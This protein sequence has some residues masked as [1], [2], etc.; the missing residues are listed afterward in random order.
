MYALQAT[1]VRGL[2][3][4]AP[5]DAPLVPVRW[6]RDSGRHGGGERFVT[7]GQSAVFDRASVNASQVHYDDLPNRR[8]GSATALSTI[9]HP[10]NPWAA[11]VHAHISYTELR[12]GMG[13]WRL[14]ADL[15]PAIALPEQTHAFRSCLEDVAPEHFLAAS[16]QGDRYFTIPALGR[17]R[18]VVHFYLEG[19]RTG[20][21]DADAH[22]ARIFGEAV[23]AL[24]PRLVQDAIA[25]HPSPGEGDRRA[26]L[27][28]HTLYL[29]QVLTLDRGTTS[30]L[31]VHDQNDLGI[32]GSLPSRVDPELFAR[33]A[34]RAPL[35]RMSWRVALWLNWVTKAGWTTRS[36]S[37]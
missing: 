5:T 31:L 24:Y 10:R 14:M 2:E 19:Y 33:W 35:P 22:L 15:N 29:F 27:H 28:Y 17:R 1:L 23:I 9:V 7:D 12:S 11:S 21:F 25:A 6:L 36:S 26:Q 34:E 32:L 4:L 30:G 16:I 8:L 37:G 18:G 13:T 20:N 3:S